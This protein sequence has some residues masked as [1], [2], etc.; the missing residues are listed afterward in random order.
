M[1]VLLE[2]RLGAVGESGEEGVQDV[3]VLYLLVAL[4]E[5]EVGHQVGEDR[6]V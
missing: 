6:K 1:N 4:E 5:V 2:A 3:L